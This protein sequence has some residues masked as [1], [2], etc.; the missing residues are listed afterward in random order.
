MKRFRPW[1]I[2]N[3]LLDRYPGSAQWSFLGCLGTE[4][5]SISAWETLFQLRR[6]DTYRLLRITDLP[7]RHAQLFSLRLGE[8]SAEI[9]S[10]GGDLTMVRDCELT[11][12][13]W[14]IVEAVNEFAAG[15]GT[16]VVLDITSL[17][18][19]YFFPIIRILIQLPPARLKNLIVTYTVPESYTKEHLAENFGDWAQLPLFNGQY[20]REKASLLVIG[21]GFE[22]LG[23]QDRVETAESGRTIAFLLP[24]PA[25]IK[26]FQRSWELLR[27]LQEHQPPQSF[28]VYRVDV[29]DASDAF[30]RLVSITNRGVRRADLAPFGPKPMSLAMCLFAAAA[31]LQV[32]YT[33]PTVYHPD[34]SIG[35]S[36]RDG[37]AETYAYAVRIDG[38]NLYTL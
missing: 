15:A 2:L 7:S 23:L 38:R 20:A 16:S 27:R 37:V 19:R 14:R 33:Q 3:W 21:V 5:R 13:H 24:F 1:G 10:A 9:Q 31:D 6:L 35:V 34:Y 4:R 32:F 17:P 26:A 22:A 36:K 29:K 30:D 28:A 12:E 8:R 18:K 11:A 25:P